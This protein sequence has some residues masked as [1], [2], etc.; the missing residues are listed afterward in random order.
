MSLTSLKSNSSRVRAPDPQ[1]DADCEIDEALWAAYRRSDKSAVTKQLLRRYLT[2]ATV[3]GLYA[4]IK[5]EP[6]AFPVQ[7][8]GANVPQA[9]AAGSVFHLLQAILGLDA[10]AHKKSLYVDVIADVDGTL[11]TREKVLTERARCCRPNARRRD[12]I[13]HHQRTAPT[14]H[15]DVDRAVGDHHAYC[16]L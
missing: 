15:A 10:N 3:A 1:S 6:G 14:R 16:R 11:V 9:W 2:A 8:L 4:G 7:Y 12:R 13:R 5:R